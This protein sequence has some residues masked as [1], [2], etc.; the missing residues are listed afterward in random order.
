MRK[1]LKNNKGISLVEVMAA[2]LVL[3]IGILGIAPLMVVTIGANSFSREITT[4]NTLAADKIESLRTIGS[5]APLPFTQF[6]NNINNKYN[7][8][9]RVDAYESDVTV[10]TG[11]YRVHVTI[12]WSDQNGIPRATEYW[13][14]L[15][16]N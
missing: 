13:T 6:E 3:A 7:R 9:T 11:V 16:R 12:S 15:S 1:I 2:M 14:Y 4:A 10:P 5:F 8:Y